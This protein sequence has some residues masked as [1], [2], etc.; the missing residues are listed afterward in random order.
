MTELDKGTFRRVDDHIDPEVKN[1]DRIS[2]GILVLYIQ[3]KLKRTNDGRFTK[4]MRIS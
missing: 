1:S 2:R 4:R 3:Q